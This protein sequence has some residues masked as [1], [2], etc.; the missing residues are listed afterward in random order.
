[1]HKLKDLAIMWLGM[2]S[3]W[4]LWIWWPKEDRNG[5]T[6]TEK[7]GLWMVGIGGLIG[8]IMILAGVDF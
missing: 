6:S 8:T 1:M 5:L 4:T 7:I 3:W 2:G